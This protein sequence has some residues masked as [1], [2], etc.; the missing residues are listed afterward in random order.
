MYVVIVC[1]DLSSIWDSTDDSDT[2]LDGELQDTGRTDDMKTEAASREE[3]LKQGRQLLEAQ[4]RRKQV[5]EETRRRKQEEE[6]RRRKQEEEEM[7]RSKQDEEMR[8]RKQ[9]EEKVRLK[10]LQLQ[11]EA[12]R[13]QEEEEE[14]RIQQEERRRQ[15]TAIHEHSDRQLTGM[16][17]DDGRQRD[18]SDLQLFRAQRQLSTDSKVCAG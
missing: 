1:A 2:S 17:G 8:R 14:E 15:M 3:M 4:V 5:E 10:Q 6:V 11:E 12:R 9:E 13:R 7:R 18:L 16:T